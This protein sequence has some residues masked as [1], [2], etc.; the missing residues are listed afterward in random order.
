MKDMMSKMMHEES[1][2]SDDKHH[3][4]KLDVLNELRDMAMS[5]MGDKM[6][7]KLSPMDEMKKVTVAA[8]DEASLKAGLDVAKM[9]VPGAIEDESVEED[10]DE[11]SEDDDMSPED[12]DAQI[13][14]LQEMKRQKSMKV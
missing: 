1:E 11:L 2:S 8:P 14:H 4:A 12:I 6:K 5:M 7:S 9:A 3:Q 10:M 13:Q